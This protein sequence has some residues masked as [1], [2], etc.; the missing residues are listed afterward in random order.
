MRIRIEKRISSA[1]IESRV[2]T[3]SDHTSGIPTLGCQ[4][5]KPGESSTSARYNG[6]GKR[7]ATRKNQ[8]ETAVVR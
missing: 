8:L 4:V 5:D 3:I 6:N 1:L 2:S 7:A